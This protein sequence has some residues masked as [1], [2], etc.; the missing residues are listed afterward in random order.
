MPDKS[1]IMLQ[2]A[3]PMGSYCPFDN[4]HPMPAADPMA[5]VVTAHKAES[6]GSL[7]WISAIRCWMR[8]SAHPL[9]VCDAEIIR[10][11]DDRHGCRYSLVTR[12]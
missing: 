4:N 1:P 6:R 2:I 11:D 3:M 7:S 8:I 9:L 12:A 10:D 5:A